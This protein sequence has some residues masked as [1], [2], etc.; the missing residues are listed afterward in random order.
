MKLGVLAALFWSLSFGVFAQTP[1][2]IDWFAGADIVATGDVDDKEG[3]RDGATVREFE[4]SANSQI[5]HTW[6]GVLTLAY[7]REL[8]QDEEHLEVHEAFLFSPKVIEGATLKLGKFFLGFGRLNRFH[9]HDW[10][11]TE[12]P[13]YHKDFFGNEGV[14]DTGVEYSKL[15]GGALNWKA[16]LGL[17]SGEEFVHTHSHHDEEE[18]EAHDHSGQP[19]TPTG[20]LRL[21]AFNEIS[22]TE[23]FETGINFI[24]RNDAEGTRYHYAG[25]DFI[26]KD[27]V[28]RYLNHVIQAE[29][30]SR[31]SFE[32]DESDGM[33]DIGGYLYYEKGFNRHHALGF[34]Y[35]F[36]QPKFH[37]GESG[38]HGHEEHR[39]ID[40][41]HVL[42]NYSAY[43]L[44]YTYTNSEF[45][46]TRLA[47]EH[48]NG[49]EIE[50]ER[51]SAT[52]IF[53]QLV[54]SIGAHPAHVY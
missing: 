8:Q 15:I 47:I 46:R 41:F 2:L 34:R 49:L 14:K 7:H 5:D 38:D 53:A 19:H 13:V 31:T 4:F 43:T 24:T 17:V 28:A 29:L 10:I 52:R 54:F 40:G 33:E 1:Q 12:A 3:I 44:S 30:W 32:D 42:D 16:T 39:D 27:R 23:G 11:F 50:E 37:E 21:S 26:Y 6:E 9:R 51:D 22:T 48:M 25:L 20:Y 36:Y 45:M 35:D 18:E